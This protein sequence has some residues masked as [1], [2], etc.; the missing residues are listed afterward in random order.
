MKKK[1]T[2]VSTGDLS[3]LTQ[4]L[5]DWGLE[6]E[7]KEMPKHTDYES[8]IVILKGLPETETRGLARR[9]NMGG[10]GF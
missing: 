5:E 1:Q 7:V 6:Y 2:I 4:A 10:I 3:V 8:K 9:H